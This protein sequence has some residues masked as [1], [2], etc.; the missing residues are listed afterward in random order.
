[1]KHTLLSA[2]S[3]IC[4]FF[5]SAAHS[6][7]HPVPIEVERLTER[8]FDTLDADRMR[9]W[10]PVEGAYT[11]RVDVHILDS[12]GQE[13]CYFLNSML[14]KGYYNFYWD[15]K[16]SLGNWVPPGQYTY[17]G[18]VCSRTLKGKLEVRYKDWEK[19]YSFAMHDS[20]GAPEFEL[21]LGK[22]SARVTATVAFR[23]GR[24]F[25]TLMQ[26]SLLM[27]GTHTFA[28]HPKLFLPQNRYVITFHIGDFDYEREFWF[29]R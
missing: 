3:A 9:V 23:G 29:T 5:V 21:T 14:Q 20:T 15:K 25:D 28:W 8:P 27:A 22:D 10:V 24:V 6:Q 1:M 2:V 7:N 11:C 4:L 26:D 13:V 17:E 16:D 18:K 19:H 12:A